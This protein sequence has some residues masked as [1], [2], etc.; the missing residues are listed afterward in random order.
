M[1]ATGRIGTMNAP[2]P[3]CGGRWMCS[4]SWYVLVPAWTDQLT[5]EASPTWTDTVVP[6]ECALAPLATTVTPAAEE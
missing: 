3:I 5:L 6:V 1:I 4:T 2:T